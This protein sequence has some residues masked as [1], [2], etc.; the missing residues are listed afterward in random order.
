[1][2]RMNSK[3]VEDIVISMLEEVSGL[4]SIDP[5]RLI[6]QELGVNGLESIEFMEEMER[7]FKISLDELVDQYSFMNE[8]GKFRKILGIKPN[9][10]SDFT[11]ND[12][13]RYVQSKLSNS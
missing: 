12:L 5:S 7:I 4:N 2:R 8:P 13:I 9:R 6:G 10:V 1:M 3:D 11:V